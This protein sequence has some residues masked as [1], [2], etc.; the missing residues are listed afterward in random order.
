MGRHRTE[1]LW[2]LTDHACAA[3]FGRVLSRPAGDKGETRI[4]RC[5]NCGAEARGH[6]PHVLCACGMKMKGGKL[7]GLRCLVNPDRTPEVPSEVIVEG[8]Q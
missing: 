7:F 8:G 3:C 1:D 4:Y 2:A 5:A 6:D